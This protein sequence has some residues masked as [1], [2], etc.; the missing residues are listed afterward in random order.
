MH[1]NVRLASGDIPDMYTYTLHCQY[2]ASYISSITRCKIPIHKFIYLVSLYCL[3][4]SFLS[5]H[6]ITVKVKLTLEEAMKAQMGSR[7]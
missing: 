1:C 4:S 6:Y 3:Y 2:A 7:G 5:T